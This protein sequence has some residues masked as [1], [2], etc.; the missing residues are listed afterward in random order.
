MTAAGCDLVRLAIVDDEAARA[1]AEIGRQVSIPLIADIHFDHKLALTA[2]AA[3][4]DGL[5]INPGNIGPRKHVEAVVAAASE[6]RVPIRIGVNGGSLEKAI[7]AKYGGGTAEA[8]VESALHHVS[9]LE[10][11]GYHEIKISVKATDVDRTLAAYRLLAQRTDYPLHLG[12]TEAG[13]LIPGIVRS[14]VAMGILLNEGIG[15]TIR[16]SLT[17]TPERE[18]KTGLELLRCL[19]LREP[20]PS[21]ISC[22][23]CGRV[24]VDVMHMAAD[25]EQ[26]LEAYYR[27]NPTTRQ[28][29]VAVM[30][31]MV[32]GPGEAREAD[33]G[34]AAGNKRGHLFVKGRNIAVVPEDE[35]VGSLS[36]QRFVLPAIAGVLLLAGLALILW[37]LKRYKQHLGERT[38]WVSESTDQQSSLDERIAAG[39]SAHQEFKSTIRKNLGSGKIGKEIEKAWLKGVVA[40]LNSEG[41]VLFFGVDDDGEALGLEADEFK[42]DDHCGRHVKNL[43]NQHIGAEFTAYTHFELVQYRGKTIGMRACQPSPEPAFLKIGQDEEFY[44]RN[45]P[46]SL[47]LTVSETLTYLKQRGLALERGQANQPVP[48]F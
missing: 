38:P 7:E 36:S 32:N 15:D 5:R 9:I 16:V 40:F 3:G 37:Q 18:V 24:Q 42:N 45:G 35:M 22:P 10:A 44:V 46:A 27:E 33:I 39:E 28:P 21:V 47:C 20:G 43:V 13:T 6:R 29:V 26:R 48:F 17:D 11:C 4:V 30:G 25:V 31:C 14:S 41:G 19:G 2:L 34:I 8:L 23:T 12:V 1:L